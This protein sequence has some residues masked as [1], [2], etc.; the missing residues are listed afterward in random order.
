MAWVQRLGYILSL[1]EAD[2]HATALEPVL[3]DGSAFF[4]ALAPPLSMA[5]AVRDARW[6]VAVNVAVEPDL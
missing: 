1:I 4:V 2:E 5:G 3:A 6:R